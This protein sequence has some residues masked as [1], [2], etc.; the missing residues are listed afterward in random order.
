ME[1]T[2]RRPAERST[3]QLILALIELA[4]LERQIASQ[5]ARAA[6]EQD[7]AHLRALEDCRAALLRIATGRLDA[8]REELSS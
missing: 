1:T 6:H 5:R 8:Q 2:T 7:R 3:T 4:R